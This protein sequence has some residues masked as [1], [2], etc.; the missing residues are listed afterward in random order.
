M[1]NVPREAR[2]RE[3]PCCAAMTTA[4]HSVNPLK[5]QKKSPA[6]PPKTQRV[7]QPAPPPVNTSCNTE[8]TRMPRD[9]ESQQA[10]TGTRQLASGRP[11]ARP[12]LTHPEVVDS[13]SLPS[14]MRGDAA[15]VP[16]R[17]LVGAWS[18][19]GRLVVGLWS[20]LTPPNSA[21]H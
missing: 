2:P 1:R 5:I 9:R 8:D 7:A 16:G 13:V 21:N 12:T 17:F 15:P 3:V 20:L 6:T 18:V 11:C 14:Q 10:G 4:A 19:G